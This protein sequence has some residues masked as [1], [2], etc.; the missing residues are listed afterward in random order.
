MNPERF[1]LK[2]R[3]PV[4]TIL[5]QRVVIFHK[6]FITSFSKKLEQFP[7]TSEKEICKR[8]EKEMCKTSSYKIKGKSP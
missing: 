1:K 2:L 6:N 4:V 3:R 7:L 8:R 5:K